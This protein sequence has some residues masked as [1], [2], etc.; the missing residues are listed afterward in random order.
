MSIEAALL[1]I[2]IGFVAQLAIAAVAIEWIHVRKEHRIRITA[3]QPATACGR[4]R[5]VCR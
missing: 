1:L 5:K 2:T 3:S 4:H